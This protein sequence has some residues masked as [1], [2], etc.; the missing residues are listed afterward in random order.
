MQERNRWPLL[1]SNVVKRVFAD[2]TLPTVQQQADNLVLWLGA[3][4]SDPG[5]VVR[6]N[7]RIFASQIGAASPKGVAYVVNGLKERGLINLATGMEPT[8]PGPTESAVHVGLTFAGWERHEELRR[9]AA[10]GWQAFMAM[11]FGIADLDRFVDVHFRPAVEATGFQ[12]RRLDDN[13]KKS[14]PDRCSPAR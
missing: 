5:K 11:P 10:S 4:Q 9:G 14:R 3:K 6:I 2:A 12:L 7:L 8:A 1:D 13:P